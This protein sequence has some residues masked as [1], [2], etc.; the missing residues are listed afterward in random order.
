MDQLLVATRPPAERR[1]YGPPSSEV[2]R[3]LVFVCQTRD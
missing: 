3:G 2:G 1:H